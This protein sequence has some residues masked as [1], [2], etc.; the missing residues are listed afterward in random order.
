MVLEEAHTVVPE[1]N[2]A[3]VSDKISQPLLNSIAQ[4]ALQG[5]KYNV[6]LLVI[7]QRTANV[8]KTI[9]TQC[10]TIIAFQVYDKTSSDFLSNYFGQEIVTL[11]PNLK[12]RQAVAAGKAFKSNVPM[13]FEVPIIEEPIAEFTKPETEE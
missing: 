6:G 1:Y 9:L 10:N 11:L 3:G 4:I 7:A 5:R 12:Y 13:V 8:S 2:F